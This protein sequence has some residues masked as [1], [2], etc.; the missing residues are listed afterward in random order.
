M[1]NRVEKRPRVGRFG[2]PD[3]GTG[4][5]SRTCRRPREQAKDTDGLGTVSAGTEPGPGPGVPTRKAG[6]GGLATAARRQG[7]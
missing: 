2:A 3:Q 6:S 1:P 5:V 4:A 7:T